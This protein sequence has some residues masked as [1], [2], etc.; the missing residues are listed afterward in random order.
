[1]GE[2][3]TFEL[4]VNGLRPLPGNGFYECWWSGP[5]S[6]PQNPKL[7]SGGTFVVGKSGSATLTMT[8]GVDPH[9]FGRMKITVEQP[10][11]GASAGMTTVLV[12]RSLT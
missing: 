11:S 5:G 1:V 9:Q 7:V 2:S 12:G 3:W 8:T 4:T 6:T 10:G